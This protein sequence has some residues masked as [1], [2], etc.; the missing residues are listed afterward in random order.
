LA[1]VLRDGQVKAVVLPCLLAATSER[2]YLFDKA[3]SAY[4]DHLYQQCV[5][6]Y[7]LPNLIKAATGDVHLALVN[8]EAALLTWI[9]EQPAELRKRCLPWLKVEDITP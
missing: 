9:T 4:L 1:D 5:R 2:D 7:L 6:A 8:E 3:L